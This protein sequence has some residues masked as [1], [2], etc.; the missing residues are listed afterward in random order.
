MVSTFTITFGSQNTV[1]PY[2]SWDEFQRAF[3]PDAEKVIAATVTSGKV[4]EIGEHIV[5]NPKE[6]ELTVETSVPV[7]ESNISYGGN[8]LQAGQ[9]IALGGQSRTLSRVA[10]RPLEHGHPEQVR[11]SINL[12]LTDKEKA[13]NDNFAFEPVLKK[14]PVSLWDA[15]LAVSN[16][17]PGKPDL[18]G[19]QFIHDA[20]A[21]FIIRPANPPKLGHTHQVARKALQYTTHEVQDGFFY[22]PE[23]DF[24]PQSDLATPARDH[25]NAHIL[26]QPVKTAREQM[27]TALGFQLDT[28]GLDIDTTIADALVEQPIVGQ[29][30]R[31]V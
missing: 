23:H 30:A 10:M 9:T 3:L 4:R 24:V 14:M 31:S 20:L 5:I 12:T 27:L 21:G 7:G 29:F 25:I 11:S 6:F 8:K 17:K 13:I 28:F 1:V 18:N 2:I 16:S 22:E 19:P 15:P 26:D